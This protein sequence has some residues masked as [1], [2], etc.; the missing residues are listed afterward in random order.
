M[1]CLNNL[2][3]KKCHNLSPPSKRKKSTAETAEM[4]LIIPKFGYCLVIAQNECTTRNHMDSSPV[5]YLASTARWNGLIVTLTTFHGISTSVDCVDPL[6]IQIFSLQCNFHAREISTRYIET[7]IFHSFHS[8]PLFYNFILEI[9]QGLAI[10]IKCKICFLH[11][12]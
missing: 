3:E 4:D 5:S 8:T 10:K 2:L 9:F 6:K 7:S 11:N 12:L 1:S